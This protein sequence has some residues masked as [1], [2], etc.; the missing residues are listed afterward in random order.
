MKKVFLLMMTFSIPF[1]FASCEAQSCCG[2]KKKKK[3]ETSEASAVCT[4]CGKNSCDQSCSDNLSEK[5]IPSCSLSADTQIERGEKV[6]S[7][8]FSKATAI[9]ELPDG[10]DLVFPHSPEIAAELNEIAAFEQKCCAAFQWEV[11]EDAAQKQVHLK[12]FGSPAVKKEFKPGFERF[13]LAHL[14]Q[15]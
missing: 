5:T 9:Y 15:K 12:I 2:G 1:L 13:G 11:R 7:K 14:L 4:K 3:G 6:I 10:Y 8:T